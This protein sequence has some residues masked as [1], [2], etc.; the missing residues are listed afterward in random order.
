MSSSKKLVALPYPELEPELR[1]FIDEVL[2]PMLVSDALKDI[3]AE[4]QLAPPFSVVRE[5]P[6][7]QD[8]E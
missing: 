1:E 7:S 2:V 4:N 3:S 8:D 5:S 6:R